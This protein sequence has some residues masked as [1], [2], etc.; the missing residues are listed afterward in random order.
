M[1]RGTVLTILVVLAFVLTG[2]S[3]L[4]AQGAAEPPLQSYTGAGQAVCPC[5][6]PGEEAGAIL[7]APAAHYP[8]EILRI[9]IGWG[10]AF[11]GTFPSVE[12]AI[13][14]YGAGLPNPGAP[15]FSLPA[16]ELNDGFINEFNIDPLPGEVIVS[17]GPFTVTLEFENSNGGD[18]FAPSMV[19]D[20]NG[21]QAGRNIVFAS[22]GTWRDACSLGVTGDWVVYVIYRRVSCSAGG[23]GSVPD[24]DLVPGAPLMVMTGPGGTIELTWGDS[25]AAGDTD[26]AVYQGTLGTYYS[27]ASFM[28][29]TSGST[30][31]NFLPSSGSKY[32]LVVPTNGTVEGSYGF[33]SAGVEIPAGVSPCHP[34]A[35]PTCP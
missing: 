23:A 3:P 25:C 26:F 9:G 8:I 11:G 33:N 7:N 21:C 5:F 31:V 35:S 28:C 12:R 15:I 13:H 1:C 16:P 24:G 27:H 20:G 2:A 4:L 32:Y 18:V 29:T 10:S 14:V 6:A 30:S 17:S 22:P 19:H 34:S